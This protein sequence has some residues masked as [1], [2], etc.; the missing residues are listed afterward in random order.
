[1]E[2]QQLS[3]ELREGN[4]PDLIRRR[5]IIGLSMLGVTMGQIVSLYQTGN[6]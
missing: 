5:W 6:S 1:M 2:P 4:S 3:R